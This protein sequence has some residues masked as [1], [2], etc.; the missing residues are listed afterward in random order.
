MGMDEMLVTD[1][2]AADAGIYVPRIESYTNGCPPGVFFGG[3]SILANADPIAV[4][5]PDI[6]ERLMPP[7]PAEL[8]VVDGAGAPN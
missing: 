8:A 7:D 4:N 5:M 3:F 1:A 6:P 2:P